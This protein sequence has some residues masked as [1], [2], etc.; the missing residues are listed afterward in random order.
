[1]SVPPNERFSFV[2]P[3]AWAHQPDFDALLARNGETG[4]INLYFQQEQHCPSRGRYVRNVYRLDNAEAVKGRSNVEFELDPSRY[5]LAVH[6]IR[7]VRDGQV[8]SRAEE[9][10]F[11]FI[12]PEEARHSLVFDGRYLVI[13]LLEDVRVGDV[14][15]IASTTYNLDPTFPGHHFGVLLACAPAG[16]DFVRAALHHPTEGVFYSRVQGGEVEFQNIPQPDGSTVEILETEYEK[17]KKFSHYAPAWYQQLPALVW[18]SYQTWGEVVEAVDQLWN[19]EIGDGYEDPLIEEC[20]ASLELDPGASIE[21]RIDRI[22]RFVQDDI[23]YLSLSEGIYSLV[24]RTPARVLAKRF[25]DCKDKSILL[26][27]LL[28]K[29]G[30]DAHPVLVNTARR[31]HVTDAPPSPGAFNHAIVRIRLGDHTRWVDPTMTGQGG[32]FGRRQTYPFGRGL[33]IGDDPGELAE[34]K[35]GDPSTSEMKVEE[36]IYLEGGKL[37]IEMVTTATGTEADAMRMQRARSGTEQFEEGLREFTARFYQNA[38]ISKPMEW[39][40]DLQ[41][42]VIRCVEHYTADAV[43]EDSPNPEMGKH[44]PITPVVVGT[45]ILVLEKGDFPVTPVALPYPMNLKHKI[46]FHHSLHGVKW[47][48]TRESIQGPGF[49][50]EFNCATVPKRVDFVFTFSTTKRHLE[51]GELPEYREKVQSVF[52]SLGRGVP[53]GRTA[54]R[55]LAWIVPLVIFVIYLL[56]KALAVA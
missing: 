6:F 2:P 3:P 37:R 20:L 42:N 55:N 22:I 53:A 21:D 47:N 48:P 49:R 10:E 45:R 14:I 39:K 29:L 50:Y 43:T 27:A 31:E 35:A 9:D 32:D 4:A 12:Q 46:R 24:P 28:R 25:G 15:D 40:D 52:A 11:R 51:T 33:V 54:A 38:A 8:V 30:V 13:H 19:R 1:M 56:L 17:P 7:V 23:R 16:S 5:R 34:I 26:A 44:Y 36:D 41:E 18:T